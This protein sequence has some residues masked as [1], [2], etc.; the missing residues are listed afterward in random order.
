MIRLVDIIL[1]FMALFVLSP[2][3]FIVMVILKCTGEHEIFYMQDRLGLDKKSFKLVKF[4]TMLK[5]SSSMS[6]GTI[7][8]RDDPRVLP[9]GKFLRAS[10][11]NE[12]P[13]L[14]NV[15][16]GDMSLIGPRPQTK[17]CFDAFPDKSKETLLSV[18]PGLSGIGS[19][20][21][22][23]E[24]EMLDGSSNPK[25]TYEDIIMPYKADL[26]IWFI[27]NRSFKLYL[28][29]IFLTLAVI[30]QPSFRWQKYL[31][32]IPAPPN[33]ICKLQSNLA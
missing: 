3:L 26:E 2:M 31:S 4:A 11:I 28:L 13:Q 24:Q 19:I 1:S 6:L 25:K 29:L 5:M 7:T 23:D 27:H 12:I 30:F 32:D 15:L 20:F 21:F 10:K 9:F 14:I 22:R 18:K 16:K 33:S 8:I 17:S